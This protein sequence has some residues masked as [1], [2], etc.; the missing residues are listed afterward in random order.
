MAVTLKVPGCD[1]F[2]KTLYVSVLCKC[3]SV[4][5]SQTTHGT[6]HQQM[7]ICLWSWRVDMGTNVTYNW[8]RL[9][10]RIT[11]ASENLIDSF[12]SLWPRLEVR[13]FSRKRQ[14]LQ[15]SQEICWR[16]ATHPWATHWIFDKRTSTVVQMTLHFD[17]LLHIHRVA[18]FL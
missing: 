1:Y 14:L 2:Y 11:A 12:L 13:R 17:F 5:W 3:V 18:S 8:C 4:V 10:W 6:F 16:F 7:S 9:S 15:N